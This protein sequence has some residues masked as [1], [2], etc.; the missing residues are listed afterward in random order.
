MRDFKALGQFAEL[1]PGGGPH[2]LRLADVIYHMDAADVPLVLAHLRIGIRVVDCMEMCVDPLDSTRSHPGGSSLATDGR[3]VW[4]VDLPYY[5]E[6]YRVALTS[7]FIA[8]VR[9]GRPIDFRGTGMRAA[10]AYGKAA[11]SADDAAR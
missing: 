8:D 4:R 9:A 10:S 2:L 11:R 6:R 3:W 7:D 5:V 1:E